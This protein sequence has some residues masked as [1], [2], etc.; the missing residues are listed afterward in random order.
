M[1]LNVKQAG[2]RLNVSAA[3]VYL[4]CASRRLRH[5]RVGVGRGKIGIPEDAIA[6]YLKG[7]EVG[8]ELPKPPPSHRPRVKYEH[9]RLP[10]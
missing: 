8:P 10:S 4:L 7:R 2:E 3:T 1:L 9:L 6:E 5:S